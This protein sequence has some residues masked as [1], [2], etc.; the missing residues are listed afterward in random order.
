[1][2]KIVVTF[3][4]ESGKR[5]QI[6]VSGPESGY[7]LSEAEQVV[8]VY[9]GKHTYVFPLARVIYLEQIDD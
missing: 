5:E 2:R 7:R 1:M 6:T 4:G 8:R 9:Q 3:V